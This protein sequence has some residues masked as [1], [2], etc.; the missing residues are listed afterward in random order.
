MAIVTHVNV[1]PLGGV[2]KHPVAEAHI[3][4]AGVAG[5]KQRD[6][7][8]HGGPQRAVS[9]YSAELIAAL[10]A[11]GH[12][13]A[14]GSTGENLTISGLAWEQLRPGDRLVIGERLQIEIT[15]Y[16]VPCT[17]IAASFRDGTFKRIGQKLNPGWSR[18]YARVL[19]EG[20]VR[21]GDPV[22]FDVE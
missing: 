3:S 7:R 19:Q 22:D 20:V 8:Y 13:V 1:N 14:P 15:S 12:P 16:A 17:Q 11:E 18:V 9:L 4:S 21:A 5:D 6:R 2:P 10:Q